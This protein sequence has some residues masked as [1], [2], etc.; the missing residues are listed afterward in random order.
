MYGVVNLVHAGDLSRSRDNSQSR[1][2]ATSHSRNSSL[3]VPDSKRNSRSSANTHRGKGNYDGTGS[4]ISA[5]L[6]SRRLASEHDNDS[7]LIEHI[8]QTATLKKRGAPALG[9]G[10]RS[11]RRSSANSKAACHEANAAVL[12]SMKVAAAQKLA[13]KQEK[14]WTAQKEL[15]SNGRK[16]SATSPKFDSKVL[17]VTTEAALTDE[18]RAVAAAELAKREA[19][20]A[21]ARD[22]KK[23]LEIL[24][25][26]SPRS[27]ARS[28]SIMVL[29]KLQRAEEEAHERKLEDQRNERLEQQ[30]QLELKQKKAAE[31]KER[32]RQAMEAV[33]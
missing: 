31:K 13:A 27:A 20:E 23:K 12:E 10:R 22:R 24:Q 14:E 5:P 7:K 6:S 26:G 29:R 8:R 17:P 1:S 16:G 3:G 25:P 18:E 4:S 2:R 28:N 19:A 11:R 21:E 30:K 33:G 15:W 32:L 9:S